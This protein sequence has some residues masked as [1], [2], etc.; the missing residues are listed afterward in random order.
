MNCLDCKSLY[1]VSEENY[2]FNRWCIEWKT[3]LLKNEKD[4]P[5]QCPACK[6]MEE[7]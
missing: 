7:S 6:E 5:T 4:E 1:K 3:W 2:Y